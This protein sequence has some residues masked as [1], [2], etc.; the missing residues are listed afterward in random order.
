MAKIEIREAVP[1]DIPRLVEFLIKLDAHVAGV[2][3]DVLGLTRAGENQL[4]HR[5]ESFIDEHGKLLVVA[6]GSDGQLVGMGNIHIW[7]F[8]DIWVNPERRGLRSGYIDDIWIEPEH[9]GGG[10]ARRIV[11]ALVNF[12]AEQEINE[13]NL[14]YALHNPEAETFWSRLGF[15]PT[16]VRA[17]AS[18]AD[19]REHLNGTLGK[20]GRGGTAKTDR[21]KT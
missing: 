8:D 7:Q 21:K 2:E 6:E 18:L 20:H 17:S 9:R 19:V 10:L 15:R 4:R 13:L 5:I 11:E 16:G 14:E 1:G 12:A 3:A